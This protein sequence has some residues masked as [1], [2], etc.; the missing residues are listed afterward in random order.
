[1]KNCLTRLKN[2]TWCLLRTL[3]L[4]PAVLRMHSRSALIELGWFKSFRRRSPVD[5]AGEPIPWWTYSAIAFLADRLPR[6]SRVL[7]F[8]CGNSTIWLSRRVREI[9]S[10]ENDHAWAERVSS[11]LPPNARV[12][13]TDSLETWAAQVDSE[14]GKFDVVI[15]DAGNRLEC[16]KHACPLLCEDGVVIWDN[17]DGPDWQ[18]IRGL[19]R[20]QG[21]AEV[22]F[23]GMVPQEICL[24]RTTVFYRENN[25]LGI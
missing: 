13:L 18:Q 22:S 3:G 12:V 14:L 10:V 7:E 16:A 24:S 20:T 8:G 25:C 4:G 11:R 23:L 1:M 15:V 17:T 9:V 6:S 5:R 2:L 21:F 19:L